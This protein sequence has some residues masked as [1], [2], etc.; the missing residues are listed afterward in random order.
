MCVCV[1]VCVCV[2]VCLGRR[3]S[4]IVASSEFCLE[5]QKV[6]TIYIYIYNMCVWVCVGVFHS[7]SCSVVIFGHNY[8]FSEK[9]VSFCTFCLMLS[10][11]SVDS[12]QA[13]SYFFP[14]LLIMVSVF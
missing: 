2:C 6:M 1:R 3:E 11:V 8:L 10:K 9:N 4:S 5:S 7:S 14:P 13:D 12:F